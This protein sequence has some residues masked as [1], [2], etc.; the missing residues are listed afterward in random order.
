MDMSDFYG[1][2]DE[3]EAVATINRA[4]G[5]GMTFLDTIVPWPA[6]KVTGSVAI[7]R[8]AVTSPCAWM[9]KTASIGF[10]SGRM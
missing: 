4:L 6:E 5:L 2:R 1:S 3:A 10:T 7:Q 9:G 8:P